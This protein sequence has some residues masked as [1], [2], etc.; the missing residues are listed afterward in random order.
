[1]F[2]SGF[3]HASFIT[4]GTL[5]QTAAGTTIDYWYFYL[6]SDETITINL[7]TYSNTPTGDHNNYSSSTGLDTV[8][9]LYSNDGSL[10]LSDYIAYNDDSGSDAAS[11]DGSTTDLDSYLTITLSA[12]EYVLLVS[13]YDYNGD[14]YSLDAYDIASSINF[15]DQLETNEGYASY[16]I[17]WSDNVYLETQSDD[18]TDVPE[19][20]ALS[21]F[22]VALL[23]VYKFRNKVIPRN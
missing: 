17:T 13:D 18:D 5:Y 1:M 4:T 14:G 21:I 9:S 23:G 12:G 2:A 19:P 11:S 22:L 10:D 20:P 15:G 3:A 6:D 16:Q 7:L 8:I